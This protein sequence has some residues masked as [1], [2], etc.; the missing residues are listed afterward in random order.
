M[1]LAQSALF[2]EKRATFPKNAG[3]I[4]QDRP[5]LML[6]TTDKDLGYARYTL[7]GIIATP[8]YPTN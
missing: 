8:R 3:K 7:Q 5:F 6:S 1:N 4:L 2:V